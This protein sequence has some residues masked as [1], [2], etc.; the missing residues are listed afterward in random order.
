MVSLF[1]LMTTAFAALDANGAKDI[2]A[3]M[4]PAGAKHLY[5]KT[6]NM[7]YKV[8]FINESSNTHYEIAVSRLTGKIM[9]SKARVR[10]NSAS[11]SIKI[12]EQQARNILLADHPRAIISSTKLIAD[13][14]YKLYHLEFSDGNIKGQYE[15]NPETG[16][17]VEKYLKY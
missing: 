12:N 2:A 13:N 8:Q 1:L 5:T 4:I 6:S 3:K 9:E 15:I 17:V 16:I 14:G 10:G 11:N 7:D